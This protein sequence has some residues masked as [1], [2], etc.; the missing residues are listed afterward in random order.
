[1]K[2]LNATTL[3]LLFTLNILYVQTYSVHGFD[4]EPKARLSYVFFVKNIETGQNYIFQPGDKI[5][6]WLHEGSS[7]KGRI[8]IIE[9]GHILI[10]NKQVRLD[11][12]KKLKL[13]SELGG[14]VKVSTMDA[15]KRKRFV[16]GI[17]VR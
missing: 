14:K 11:D 6:Y 12:L 16:V 4:P 1:M 9:R 2:N 5:K 13:P 3:L 7:G 10:D 8:K 17:M 15:K